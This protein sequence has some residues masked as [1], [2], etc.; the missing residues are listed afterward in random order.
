ML[1]N[2]L[3]WPKLII[4]AIYEK[5]SETAKK[6]NTTVKSF[7]GDEKNIEHISLVIYDILPLAIKLGYRYEQFKEQFTK[8]FSSIRNKIYSYEEEL[9]AQ[10]EETIISPI[11]KTRARKTKTNN[12]NSIQTSTKPIRKKSTR[13]SKELIT[14]LK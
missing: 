6:T 5:L 4:A 10:K 12:D 3:K 9:Q 1:F 2:Y 11:K 8:H 7:L 13:K 14:P